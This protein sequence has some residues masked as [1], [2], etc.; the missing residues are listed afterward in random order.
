MPSGRTSSRSS[1]RASS[2][3]RWTTTAR[4]RSRASTSRTSTP[5]ISRRRPRA[6]PELREL[7]P[8]RAAGVPRRARAPRGLRAAHAADRARS[9]PTTTSRSASSGSR[10]AWCRAARRRARRGS[11]AAAAGRAR[12]DDD[13]Q[14]AHAARRR[15]S[16][17]EDVALAQEIVTLT[18]GRKAPRGRQAP[19]GDRPVEGLRHPALRPERLAPARRAAPGGLGVLARRPR[20]DERLAGERPP[21]CTREARE[22]RQDHD[23]LD[24]P[25]L[26]AEARWSDR[27]SRS[28]RRRRGAAHPEDP[29]PLLLYLFIWRIVRTASRDLRLPQESFVLDAGPGAGGRPGRRA[30]PRRDR[31]ARRRRQPA[32]D[33]ATSACST[34]APV[35]SG[36]G[37]AERH[38]R[39]TATTSPRRA[40]R[41]SS[42][43]AT[44]SGSRTPARRTAP[45]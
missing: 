16:P 12:R 4:S 10:R 35:T 38:R 37:A 39:S 29:L 11:R 1:S 3:R 45:T 36:R 44:A 24:R 13:L 8:E 20:L 23:R 19:H 22:R 18:V 43:A 40:T 30:T 7:A 15:R 2:S 14:A 5:S 26:R 6:V 27:A 21:H 31:P 17:A 34:R 25:P 42:R 33:A 28:H 9:R 32:L 41:G